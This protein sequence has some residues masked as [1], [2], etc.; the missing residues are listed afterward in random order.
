M[1]EVKGGKTEAL[2]LPI[3]DMA[4]APFWMV[5][6][7]VK[8]SWQPAP[9]DHAPFL[10]IIGIEGETLQ[11]YIATT[12]KD[13][14]KMRQFAVDKLE[15]DTFAATIRNQLSKA[16]T[17]LGRITRKEY[18]IWM[19][20]YHH[21]ALKM[22]ESGIIQD[23]LL[24]HD[25]NRISLPPENDAADNQKLVSTIVERFVQQCHQNRKNRVIQKR[26]FLVRIN[27]PTIMKAFF[28]WRVATRGRTTGGS[29]SSMFAEPELPW[30]VR[31][32]HSSFTHSWEGIQA[33]LLMY[34]AFTVVYRLSFNSPP[35]GIFLF[36]EILI[37]LY[38]VADVILNLHTAYYDNA[39]DLVGVH[40][41]ADGNPHV[42][43]RTLYWNYAQ[44][45]FVIDVISVL[46]VFSTLFVDSGLL[47]TP[48]LGEEGKL[49]K[50]LRL[51]RL[52]KLLR[53]FRGMRIFQ[54]Y[55]EALGPVVTGLAL[56]TTIGWVMHSVACF[57]FVLGIMPAHVNVPL[58]CCRSTYYCVWLS[59][60]MPS[61]GD[62]VSS[63]IGAVSVGWLQFTYNFNHC[64][65]Y[66]PASPAKWIRTNLS[67]TKQ[68]NPEW[69]STYYYDAFEDA[70][71]HTQ[72]PND[73]ALETCTSHSQQ[74]KANNLTAEVVE[75]PPSHINYYVKSLFTVFKNPEI[76]GDCQI[77]SPFTRRYWLVEWL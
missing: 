64:D 47:D 10:D 51:L 65:C 74:W 53:L 27:R 1:E 40:T 5:Y 76:N 16:V 62:A 31:H 45:W 32:P 55:E 9:G 11:N 46:P 35:E 54:K 28:A 66:G 60:T 77:I 33:L 18:K 48:P 13:Q 50:T 15:S 56:I 4:S 72:Y 71:I 12:V 36:L 23:I 61:T 17:D 73:K 57:W 3:T 6:D 39:G 14:Q 21:N 75:S 26:K 68:R 44:G 59:G 19:A 37:D 30:Y 25:T 49:F 67:P 29:S 63:K 22:I 24:A 58:V 34:V 70:C 7:V 20:K 42:D 38:F 52:A 41:D 2:L 43:L 69:K 8:L